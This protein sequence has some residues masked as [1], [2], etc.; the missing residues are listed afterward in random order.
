MLLADYD[1]HLLLPEEQF[2]DYQR[3]EKSIPKSAGHHAEWIKA[4]KTGSPTTCNFDYS[5]ALAETVLLGCVAHKA[6]K[7]ID[8]DAKAMKVTNSAEANRFLRR[9]YR[10]GW[11]IDGVA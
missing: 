9:D 11:E 8:W 7:K 4:C 2:K 1:R 10:K 6:G 3:P 5:G